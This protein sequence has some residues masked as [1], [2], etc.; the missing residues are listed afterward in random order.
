MEANPGEREHRK[1]YYDK[2]HGLPVKVKKRKCI[3][4]KAEFNSFNDARLCESCKRLIK[5]KRIDYG[6]VN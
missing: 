2:K 4:C 5:N 3:N 6:M 1:Y